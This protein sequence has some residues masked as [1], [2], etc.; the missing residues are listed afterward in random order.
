MG[1]LQELTELLPTLGIDV[2]LVP[3]ALTAVILTAVFAPSANRRSEARKV[4]GI[5]F[6]RRR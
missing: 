4:L 2:F 1:L 3:A 5:V 6:R